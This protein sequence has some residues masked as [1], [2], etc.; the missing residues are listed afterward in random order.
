MKYTKSRKMITFISMNKYNIV[1]GRQL[2]WGRVIK[3]FNMSL[4]KMYYDISIDIHF[5]ICKNIA[6]REQVGNKC[7]AEGSNRTSIKTKMWN[8]M[9]FKLT[10]QSYSDQGNERSHMLLGHTHTGTH[11]HTV[12]YA[13]SPNW[14]GIKKKKKTWWR[15]GKKKILAPEQRK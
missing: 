11:T 14:V 4:K 13:Q 9:S 15:E 2:W 8:Q 7:E 12:T 1:R 5:C 10:S 3:A 6:A